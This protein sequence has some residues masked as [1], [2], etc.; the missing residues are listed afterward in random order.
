MEWTTLFI[1]GG[2][3]VSLIMAGVSGWK[4]CREVL[5]KDNSLEGRLRVSE[6]RGVVDTWLLVGCV[7]ALLQNLM[8]G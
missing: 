6:A 2:C 4:L 7:L 3:I 1:S 5:K 8:K